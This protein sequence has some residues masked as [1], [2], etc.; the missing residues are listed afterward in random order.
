MAQYPKS[1]ALTEADVPKAWVD[2]LNTAIDA[3][4][5]PS[6]APSTVD[7]NGGVP[8]YASG[9]DRNSP[10]VCANSDRV[11]RIPQDVWDAPDG[12][13]GIGF[14]DGPTPDSPKLY[15][16]LKENNQTSTQYMIGSN[17]LDNWQEFQMA[18]NDLGLDIAV[19]TWTHPMMTTRTN[20]QVL[21]ELGWTLQIIYD[22]TNGKLPRFWRPPYGDIDTRVSA[23]AREVFG[24]KAVLW[25]QDTEDWSMSDSPPGTTL[26]QI[27]KDMTS[28][29]TGSKSPGLIILEHELT[30]DTIQAF[31]NAWPM[32]S[33]NGW[34]PVS[35]AL[36]NSSWGAVYQNDDDDDSDNNNDGDEGTD[37]IFESLFSSDSTTSTSSAT[38]TSSG[39]GSSTT[40]GGAQA[41]STGQAEQGNTSSGAERSMS[42]NAVLSL[43]VSAGF[44]FLLA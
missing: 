38:A 2:A 20:V 14:D 31:I 44:F 35:Q 36:L 18:Y 17:V 43:L 1:W 3:G 28:W 33:Q 5:I 27:E 29:L 21:G 15:N 39:K 10:D 42:A 9:V 32:I 37:L 13:I 25:N 12:Y 16:F 41:S 8:N 24:M 19:H 11:C 22:A 6:Y 4:K 23:I 34:K 7:P 30:N 40:S 26:T